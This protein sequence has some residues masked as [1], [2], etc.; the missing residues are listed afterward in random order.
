MN[1]KFRIDTV[2]VDYAK[3][4][5]PLLKSPSGGWVSYMDMA[6]AIL[7]DPKLSNRLLKDDTQKII[8]KD[9]KLLERFKKSEIDK[10]FLK[11]KIRN[12]GISITCSEYAGLFSGMERN[13]EIMRTFKDS[14][15]KKRLSEMREMQSALQQ[16]TKRSSTRQLFIKEEKIK[17][18]DSDEKIASYNLSDETK[19]F[20]K[21]V[22]EVKKWKKESSKNDSHY[23]LNE[24]K[25][26]IN[27]FGYSD[28]GFGDDETYLTNSLK[29]FQ[30]YRYAD[31]TYSL[32]DDLEKNYDKSKQPIE[33]DKNSISSV[34]MDNIPGT[35]IESIDKAI[36]LDNI[37]NQVIE[38]VDRTKKTNAKRREEISRRSK[39]QSKGWVEENNR[40]F[41]GIIA[42]TRGLKYFLKELYNQLNKIDD[43][44]DIDACFTHR[45]KHPNPDYL[46]SDITS[47]II[48]YDDYLWNIRRDDNYTYYTNKM[49][50]LV[51]LLKKKDLT[52]DDFNSINGLSQDLFWFERDLKNKKDNYSR[53]DETE[54]KLFEAISKL[55]KYVDVI[56]ELH[57]IVESLIRNGLKDDAEMNDIIHPV[58]NLIRFYYRGYDINYIVSLEKLTGLKSRCYNYLNTHCIVAKK[59][60]IVAVVAM[61][62]AYLEDD[63][64]DPYHIIHPFF[65]S[66]EINVFIDKDKED[67]SYLCS[68]Y[69]FDFYRHLVNSKLYNGDLDHVFINSLRNMLDLINL[70]DDVA[71]SWRCKFILLGEFEKY[72]S[73]ISKTNI[74]RIKE[75]ALY[76]L[77]A[78]LTF[79]NSM[80][81]YLSKDE[82]PHFKENAML[83]MDIVKNSIQPTVCNDIVFDDIIIDVSSNNIDFIDND[84]DNVDANIESLYNKSI[85]ECSERINQFLEEANSIGLKGE[86]MQLIYYSLSLY[87]ADFI[88]HKLREY[89]FSKK[90]F[91]DA[92]NRLNTPL[93]DKMEWNIEKYIIRNSYC[94]ELKQSEIINKTDY[95]VYKDGGWSFV[96]KGQGK[97]EN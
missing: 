32:I 85:A 45:L 53:S 95:I 3:V 47:I 24:K 84:T 1:R 86:E 54:S 8:S 33:E 52:Y 61:L 83:I 38:H 90:R 76:I 14:F 13:V 12:N 59:K 89:G 43:S 96:S 51:L 73:T 41:G 63:F 40:D 57:P 65:E 39:E 46:P 88:F 34:L 77:S 49:K 10:R 5:E 58:L 44:N 91:L 75:K 66:I 2:K 36:D 35:P 60:S 29:D 97:D 93:Y 71:Y 11:G 22:K 72:I 87:V 64:S 15:L 68:Y 4:I 37:L 26:I 20:I 67:I 70:V 16:Y 28:D 6:I 31:S 21:F 48:H 69:C 79:C 74:N 50:D 81:I 25:R 55:H 80:T 62:L 82:I 56:M 19:Q 9:P 42:D 17:F 94:K 27:D 30:I 92:L 18:T 23:E 78:V 7:N